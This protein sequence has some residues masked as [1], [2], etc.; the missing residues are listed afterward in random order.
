MVEAKK[1]ELAIFRLYNKY[2]FLNCLIN[3]KKDLEASPILKKRKRKR[4]V[5]I[6]N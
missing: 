2:P 1:K 4:L 5:I 6:G 3:N